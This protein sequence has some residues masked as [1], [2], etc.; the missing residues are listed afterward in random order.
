M[1]VHA[2]LSAKGMTE[3][4]FGLGE[5]VGASHQF[6]ELAIILVFEYKCFHQGLTR[7]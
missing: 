7:S 5:S 4:D 2:V 6:S 3:M 1:P